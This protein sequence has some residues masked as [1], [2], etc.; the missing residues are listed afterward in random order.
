M[1]GTFEE[2]EAHAVG[3]GIEPA[4]VEQLEVEAAQPRGL[5]RDQRRSFRVGIFDQARAGFARA[6]RRGLRGAG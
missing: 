2:D 3:A 6:S 5:D 1:L 4:R